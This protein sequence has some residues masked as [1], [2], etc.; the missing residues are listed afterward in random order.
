MLIRFDDI[1]LISAKHKKNTEYLKQRLRDML[2]LY[3]DIENTKDNVSAE[4][5]ADKMNTHLKEHIGN[6]LV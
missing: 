2:D 4:S 3:A 5:R 1:V 6:K